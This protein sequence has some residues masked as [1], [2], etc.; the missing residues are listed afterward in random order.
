M[1]KIPTI[2]LAAMIGVS[3]EAALCVISAV[4]VLAGG[5]GPCGPTGDVP[6]FVSVIHQPGFW[7][8]G[9]LVEDSSPLYLVLSV[10][11]TTVMLCVLAY[12]ALRISHER[13]KKPSA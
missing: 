7:L 10:V 5:I 11:V 4:S 6:I 13:H 8:S 3:T 2:L 1:K 12:I 9:C